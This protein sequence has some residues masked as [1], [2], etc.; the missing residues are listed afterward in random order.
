MTEDEIKA[1]YK[2]KI[3]ELD[4]VEHY[5]DNKEFSSIA[6]KDVEIIN[7]K[8][9]VFF[10]MDQDT[11]KLV[12]VLIRPSQGTGVPIMFKL[13]EVDLMKKYGPPFYRDTTSGDGGMELLAIWNF[14]STKI[15]LSYFSDMRYNYQTLYIAYM[16]NPKIADNL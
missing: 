7:T 2:D 10:V 15:Q 4:T 8:F 13:L 3:I 5:N 14:P 9:N 11:K 16:R 6:L 1:V 12:E